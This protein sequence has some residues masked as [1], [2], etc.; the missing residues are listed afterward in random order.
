MT[1]IKVY[2][3][4]PTHGSVVLTSG[5]TGTAWQRH[6]KDGL[7]HST[8]GHVF[9]WYDVNQ[10]WSTPDIIVIYNAPEEN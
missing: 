5:P 10:F 1:P 7:W 3:L 6:F 2:P 9:N 4:E 8:T